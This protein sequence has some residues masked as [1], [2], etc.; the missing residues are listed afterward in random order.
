[1]AKQPQIQQ[2]EVTTT[3]LPKYAEP[4]MMN[5]LARGQME[6]NREY[7]PYGDQ[8]LA[9]FTQGQ[10][11][12][13]NMA[14]DMQQ[15]GQYGTATN[16]AY[17]SGLGALDAG[18]NF[19][20][21]QFNA[22]QVRAPGLQNYQMQGPGDVSAQQN[23]APQMRAAQ[24]NYNPQ[25]QDYQMQGPQNVGVSQLQDYQMQGPQSYTGDQV[26]QYM[27]PYMQNVVDVQKQQAVRDAK[28]GQLVGNLGATRQGTYGGARQL[29]AGTERE[30]NLGQQMGQI[31]ATGSQNAFQNA[32]QQFNTQ[33]Q[34]QQN[35]NQQ[36]LAARLGIQQL[37][38][39]QNMQSALANQQMGYNTG[40]QNLGANLQ[41]QG[42][43][44]TTGTQIAMANLTNQQQARVQNQAA[45]LQQ[46]GLNQQQ[47]LQ[48]ALA[49]QQMGYN[50]GNQ[51]LAARL[52][53]QQLG[54][55]Q[56]LQAQMAN[57]QYGMDAQKAAE[58]SRQFGANLGMQ[59]YQQANQAAQ[60]LGNLGTSQQTSD[61]QRMQAMASA[62]REQQAYN[63]QGMDMRYADFMRQ[64]D[65][66]M[67]QLGYYSNMLRGLPITM[68]S[69]A[70]TYAPPPSMFGQVANAG[71]AAAGAYKMFQ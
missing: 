41:T 44:T 7:T 8:R 1:M 68:G 29:L 14:I 48:A 66:P 46:M 5:M 37:G 47:A 39:G 62:G 55:S 18:R 38:A 20:P 67:E 53:V 69:T 64:R 52:G 65:Y 57:Q 50:V 27:S 63:Q 13:Q 6:S 60:N 49:N 61:M 9:G 35:A 51:N 23:N 24:T 33:Q 43:R 31:Q 54:S 21:G 59:G 71:L 70:T 32:Q 36:N 22:Q 45:S 16:M 34:A 28:M 40:Q 10:T 3:N 56:A 17:Q 58:M 25:F 30:R 4:Y 15:P 26:S 42:L 2:Q 12:A 11:N 19:T